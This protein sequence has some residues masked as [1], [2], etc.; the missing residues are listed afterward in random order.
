MQNRSIP[1]IAISQRRP[2]RPREFDLDVA[3]DGAVQVF[4]ERGFQ[5]ASLADLCAAMHL[6]TGSLYK[7]FRGKRA[8][9]LAAFDRYTARRANHVQQAVEAE[10]LGCDKLRAMLNCYVEVS[11][12]DEGR[13]GCLVVASAAELSTYDTDMA[14]IVGA[15]L[16]RVEIQLRDLIRLGQVDASISASIDAESTARTLL[17]FLQG[18]R[19]VGKVGRSRTEMLS[20]TDQA[21]RLLA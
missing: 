12:G 10:L 21:M 15:A 20:A 18:L 5:A 19:V 3:L 7:A 13:R 2:G 16:R 8:V 11:L 9:F 14:D 1:T 4:R 17:C 6:A